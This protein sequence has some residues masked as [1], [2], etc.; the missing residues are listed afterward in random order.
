[1]SFRRA[2]AVGHL[3]RRLGRCHA[4]ASLSGSGSRDERSRGS[5]SGGGVG[6]SVSLLAW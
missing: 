4:T 1:L 3:F 6:G 2:A 5:G